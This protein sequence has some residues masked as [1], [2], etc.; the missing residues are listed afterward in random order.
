VV[1]RVFLHPKANR[2]LEKSNEDLKGRIKK[3]LKTLE[4]SPH[5]KG[6][7]LVNSCFFKLRIGDYRAV[8][9]IWKQENKVVVLF[10]EHRS[11]VYDDFER[12]L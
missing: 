5:T 2:F 6:A 10:I 7:R 1:F 4:D 3:G 12:I 11:K 9:E 8:Y